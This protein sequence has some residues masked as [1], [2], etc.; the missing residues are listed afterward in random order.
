MYGSILDIHISYGIIGDFLLMCNEDYGIAFTV[1]LIEKTHYLNTSFRIEC[2]CRFIGQQNSRI[3]NKCTR[4]R[5]TLSLASR[6]FTGLMKHS[7]S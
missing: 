6:E 3:R 7:I 5:D 2:S 4:Y 1:K